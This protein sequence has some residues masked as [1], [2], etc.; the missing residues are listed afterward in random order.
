MNAQQVID[1]DMMVRIAEIEIEPKDADSYKAI[2]KEEAS[3]SVEIEPGVIAIF[4]MYE[5]GDP[6]RIRILE[7]YA[8]K[9]AYESH[10]QSPHFKRYK[11]ATAN[12]VKSLRLMDM[13]SLDKETM[14]KI[15][16]K[17]N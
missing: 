6:A 4:P 14:L 17:F 12:M 8:N 11:I 2:L 16:D 15:F 1:Q 13:E 3:A 9:A 10:L 7:I 5:K